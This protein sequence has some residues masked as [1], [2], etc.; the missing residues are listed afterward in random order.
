LLG[1][2]GS[3]REN[4]RSGEGDVHRTKCEGVRI[5]VKN[6]RRRVELCFE[7]LKSSSNF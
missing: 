4:E 1:K 2:S 7:I 3:S 5:H 6:T